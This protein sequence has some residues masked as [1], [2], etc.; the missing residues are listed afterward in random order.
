MP[1]SGPELKPCPFCDH[2]AEFVEAQGYPIS[3]WRVHCDYCGAWAD[4]KQWN[5]RAPVDYAALPEVQAMIAG[6]YEAAANEGAGRAAACGVSEISGLVRLHIRALTPADAIAARDAMIAA[7][8]EAVDMVRAQAFVDG[9]EAGMLAERQACAAIADGAA[10][11]IADR[12]TPTS[13]VNALR[14]IA[15]SIRKRGNV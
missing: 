15:A 13:A 7:E 14:N 5:R 2:G 9:R 8:R 11:E 6:A 4:G 1:M 10:L 3:G 12:L